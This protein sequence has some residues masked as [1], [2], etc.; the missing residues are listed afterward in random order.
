MLGGDAEVRGEG[1]VA[2]GAPGGAVDRG[3]DGLGDLAH[4]DGVGVAFGSE[5]K[6]DGGVRVAVGAF[7]EVGA[8]A[9]AATG[10]CQDDDPNVVVGLGAAQGGGQF[11]TGVVADRI[12]GFR[13]VEGDRGDSVADIVEDSVVGHGWPFRG[14]LGGARFAGDSCGFGRRSRGRWRGLVSPTRPPLG[15]GRCRGS[16][17]APGRAL[18]RA[19]GTE[20]PDGVSRTEGSR[21]R[22]RGA[23]PEGSE[24]PLFL[25]HELRQALAD[26]D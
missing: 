10:A 24:P 20:G 5:S 4:D 21:I 2:A 12:E 25:L 11:A 14:S 22:A 18:L 23:K 3:D 13:A 16:A 1:H 26:H 7:P 6:G 19:L 9:E 17:P 8:G 15:M